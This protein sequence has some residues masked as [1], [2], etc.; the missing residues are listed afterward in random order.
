MELTPIATVRSPLKEPG[1]CPK[2]NFEGA[3]GAAVVVD[4]AYE[5]AA[6]DIG[7][8]DELIVVTW[9]DRAERQRQATHPRGNPENPLTGV[10]STRS[11]H[12]PNPLGLHRVRVV[13]RDGLRL[14]V[15]RLEVLDHTPVVDIKPALS[16]QRDGGR[17]E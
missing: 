5:R 13:S 15:D 14:G 1:E 9:L 8:G 3:P 2:Q 12:R 6:K 16:P 7:V 17:D 4:P 11:P 10:F